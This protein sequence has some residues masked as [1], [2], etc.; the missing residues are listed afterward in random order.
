[1]NLKPSRTLTATKLGL[2]AL[3]GLSSLPTA[4]MIFCS[5]CLD[6]I[7]SVTSTL[8]TCIAAVATGGTV[9]IGGRHWGSKEQSSFREKEESA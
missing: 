7:V 1:M 6:G 5:P 9:A 4:A 2:Y 8:A 3:L